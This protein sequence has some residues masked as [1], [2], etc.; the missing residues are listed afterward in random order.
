MKNR[1]SLFLLIALCAG[2]NAQTGS[3]LQQQLELLQQMQSAGTSGSSGSSGASTA[4][5]AGV[6]SDVRFILS[7]PDY[8]VTPGDVYTLAYAAGGT[9]TVQYAIPVD[10]SYKIRVSNLGVVNAKGKTYLQ[11]KSEVE[12]IVARNYP[13]SGVQLVLTQAGVFK[14]QVKG[15]VKS[16]Q[17]IAASGVTRL[18]A[19]VKFLSEAQDQN[20]QTAQTAQTTDDD[21]EAWTDTGSLT[22]LSS[23]R[24]VTVK[25]SEGQTRTFDLFRAK[26]EGDLSQDPYLRPGDTVTFHRARRVVTLTGEVER[27]GRYQLLDGENLQALIENYGGGFTP[28]ANRS[29]MEL[30]RYVNSAD[31][32]GNKIFLSAQDI[33]EDFP[34]EDY[35]AVSVSVVTNL[36][37]VIFVEGAVTNREESAQS[38][39]LATV[40]SATASTSLSPANR[41]IVS[42][43]K[44]ETYAS[45]VRAHRAWFTS[46]SDTRN[47][48]VIRGKNQI[49]LNLN[50]MLYD[51][52]YQG[53][54]YMEANDTLIVPYRQ[55][56]VTV[57]G[58]VSR[59]GQY[60]YIPDRDWEYYIALAGGFVRE[61][62]SFQS[63][64]IT[65]IK[66][67]RMK[68]TDPIS[69]E[70]TITANTNAFLYYFNQYATPVITILTIITT[71]LSVYAALQ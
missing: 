40:L 58:A 69:P 50:Q 4:T 30:L 71:F 56:F 21:E 57:A 35:D 59:P 70:T 1:L 10:S 2:L 7:V 44:G 46:T 9:S 8:L 33:A 36:R 54:E 19:L 39:S 5:A 20:A 47:A 43:N 41:L 3:S 52:D 29:G 13:L 28:I 65:D 12:S 23:L 66:G 55:Y 64:T 6:V 34:L 62:N 16:A 15:E 11:L 31:G 37:P 27:A 42:F 18:S 53:N 63:I 25:N 14:V 68:K 51:A 24:D 61:R 60:P 26:R 17:E 67:N 48:Y 49:F 22:R 32:T 45:L 38:G